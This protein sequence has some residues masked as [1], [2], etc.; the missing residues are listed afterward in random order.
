[1]IQPGG[2]ADQRR[3]LRLTASTALA[4]LI[5]ALV[6]R[7]GDDGPR[8]WLAGLASAAALWPVLR[9][10]RPAGLGTGRA[11]RLNAAGRVIVLGGLALLLAG[12]A[13]GRFGEQRAR[14]GTLC[15]GQ[16]AQMS[17]WNL[18]LERITPVAGEGFTA[19]EAA[20]AA[21]RE[22]ARPITPEPQLRST[23]I[24]GPTP[25]PASR[26]ALWSGD[27][28]LAVAGFDPGTGCLGLNASWR[29]LAGLA[30]IGGWLAAF[31]AALIA[32]VALGALRW[33]RNA[34]E[35]ISM[36]REDRPLPDA[37]GAVALSGRTGRCL[38]A[39]AL[40]LALCLAGYLALSNPGRLLRPSGQPP[41]PYAGGAS[42]IKARQ[43]LLEGPANTN[44]WIVI[45][46]ALARRGRFAD[47]SELLL[48]AVEA[49]PRDPDG[50]LALGDALYGHAG[51][52]L[53]P[54]AS[55]A[56]D[57]ADRAALARGAALPPTGLAMEASGRGELAQMWW[58]RALARPA[59]SA[60]VRAAIAVR[61]NYSA[62]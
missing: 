60:A 62:P 6:A 10:P 50:W 29:P 43:S 5:C 33:R 59:S 31:G 4:A 51:G 45:G 44:R 2:L 47:A 58:R 9:Y 41:V 56:Y 36:R 18:R 7:L 46:D 54:A 61:L 27:L 48:G 37:G 13:A 53:T 39:A 49:D 11:D 19:I 16:S 55:L 12:Y 25:D 3:L 57:R 52:Q 40:L 8:F 35:R 28:A 1:M 22:Q 38:P 24:A 17:G 26:T 23:F 30:R 32:L 34:R 20:I 14:I 15:E 42:L 21:S